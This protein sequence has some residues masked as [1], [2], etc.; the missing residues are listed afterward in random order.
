MRKLTRTQKTVAALA[1]GAL[2]V[3]GTGVAWAYWSVDGDGTGTATT[4]DT[5]SDFV[6][7]AGF[8][9]PLY[10]GADDENVSYKVTN[11]NDEPLHLG[12]IAVVLTTNEAG[13][14]DGDDFALDTYDVVVDTMIPAN[15]TVPIEVATGTLS[16]LDSLANQNDCKGA[17][18]TLTL[19]SEGTD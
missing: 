7:S 13:C 2:G 15:T 5:V 10:P 9:A 18:V 14:V 12:N 16:F 8:S 1:I 3:A 6:L 4:G 11:T 17:T 19:S